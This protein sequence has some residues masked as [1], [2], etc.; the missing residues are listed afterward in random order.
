MSD[1]T[2]KP[3]MDE[4]KDLRPSAWMVI[5]LDRTSTF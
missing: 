3:S 5:E 4:L 1:Y 2:G